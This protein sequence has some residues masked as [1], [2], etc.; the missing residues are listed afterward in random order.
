[1]KG[2]DII[3]SMTKKQI[4]EAKKSKEGENPKVSRSD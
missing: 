3:M 2:D 4:A 1:M